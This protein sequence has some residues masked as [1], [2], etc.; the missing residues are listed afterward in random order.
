MRFHFSTF[1]HCPQ[2]RIIVEDIT[3]TMGEQ[4]RALGFEPSWTTEPEFIPFVQ[5][6]NVVLESFADD[7]QTIKRIRRAHEDGCRFIYVATEE[8]TDNGFNHG[9]E[10]AMIERQAAFPKAAL[11]CDGILHLV[12]GDAVTRWYDRFA[13]A[14]Y[15]ELGYAP[16][17]VSRERDIEP[18]VDFGF[19]G[20]M[21]W[22]REQMLARL[23]AMT[24]KKVGRI[25]SLDVPRETRNQVMRQAKVIV[26]IRANE[27]WGMVSST[28]C[29]SALSFGR[30]VVAEPHPYSKPWDEI[31]TFSKT[32]EDF[33]HDAVA[34]TNCWA[35]LH[36]SQFHKFQTKLTPEV[37]IGAP[38]KRVLAFA[39]NNR[40][41]SAM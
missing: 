38:L 24:G 30:P 17:L 34:A 19:F 12:P 31:V 41:R 22:R 4:M 35:D 15:A 33:Y 39:L 10:P 26:Q 25:T 23:E 40:R 20:K 8:P 27:E 21:T 5:G 3:R 36:R 7:P 13:P 2:G 29:A 1:N 18:E 11:Y 37:C 6:Y 28:R 16:N 14:A 9:L 32:V